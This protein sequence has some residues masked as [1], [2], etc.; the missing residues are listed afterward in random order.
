M[1]I[2]IDTVCYQTYITPYIKITTNK[3]LNGN[4]EIILG[5]FNKQIAI[6]L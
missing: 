6:I 5:W 2:S 4:Y 1:K 3:V